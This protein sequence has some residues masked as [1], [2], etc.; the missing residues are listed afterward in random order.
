[1][2]SGHNSPPALT[3]TPGGANL[4]PLS[5]FLH[6]RG[7]TPGFAAGASSPGRG[8]DRVRNPR[9]HGRGFFICTSDGLGRATLGRA[10]GRSSGLLNKRENFK[11]RFSDAVRYTF[12]STADTVSRKDWL[13]VPR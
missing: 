7:E 6:G 12:R 5:N 13:L 9:L 4:S 10:Q 3:Q 2:D 8:R 1:V 11:R